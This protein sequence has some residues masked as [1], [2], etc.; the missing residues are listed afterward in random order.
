MP[1]TKITA[2]RDS[3]HGG[4]K[5]DRP[6]SR[7]ILLPVLFVYAVVSL[8][9]FGLRLVEERIIA[10]NTALA[11]ESLTAEKINSVSEYIEAGYQKNGLVLGIK[12]TAETKEYQ[13]EL[14]S[15]AYSSLRML[16]GKAL[17]FWADF[18]NTGTQTWTN[19]G[20]NFIALNVDQPAGRL[21]PFKHPYW[22]EYFYR[23]CRLSQ[24]EVKPGEVGRFVFALK[25]PLTPGDY[26]ENFGLVAENK[27]WIV[28]G[29]LSIPVEVVKP[30]KAELIDATASSIKIEPG[31]ALTFEADFRNRG[32]ATWYN[33]GKNYIA[34]NVSN[35]AGRQSP[36]K[37]SFWKAYYRPCLLLNN[38]VKPG[39]IGH[40][41]FALQAP[42]T[43]GNYEENFALVAENLEW[44]TG[45]EISIPATVAETPAI[46]PP[47]V[48]YQA[49]EP[50]I[51]IGLYEAAGT[52]KI[53]ANG[54][55]VLKD[56]ANNTLTTVSG[57]ESSVEFI[58][59][60]YLVKAPDYSQSLN[61]Y[62]RFSSDNPDTV[63]EIT[64]WS[65]PTDWDNT[66]ND[67]KFRG[68]LEIR[69]STSSRKTWVINELP[70][71]TYLRGLGEA[72]GDQPKEYLK[73]LI[74]A[75]RTYA[76]YHIQTGG[77]K[78]K[79]DNFILDDSANDQIYRGYN[80]ELRSPQI[81][82]YVLETTGQM[83]TYQSEVV[84]TPYF[85]RSDGRTRAWTEVFGGSAKP[86]LVSVSDPYCQGMSL[87]GHGVGLSGTGARSMAQNENKAWQEILRYYYT[88]V[89]IKKI[90]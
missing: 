56:G 57:E 17:T 25:G 5:F 90:Y 66:I 43:E 67:N 88:D 36:F 31:K 39:E 11:E 73:A 83:V 59:G 13:A 49:G 6:I 58:T 47:A 29:N 20:E 80:V 76:M 21:S 87:W 33:T 35:P 15:Q 27:E 62:V 22:K 53:K 78:H 30:Y 74:T 77:Q 81:T 19:T 60:Q 8:V 65:N 4:T 44:I 54:P 23:P 10:K 24:A 85:S 45:G 28:G 71:E 89:E 68:A 84:V 41:R 64:S 86:W 14:I 46:L 37:H 9:A 55:Y 42:Q 1:K 79:G 63:F 16:P 82:T 38:G 3:V 75:A 48:T 50:N 2:G 51:R 72:S 69:Y 52:V 61:N 40:F 34:L 18:K 7:E 70:L 26:L 12:T 32:T